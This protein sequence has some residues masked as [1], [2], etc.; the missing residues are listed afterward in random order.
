MPTLGRMKHPAPDVRELADRIYDEV[1]ARLRRRRIPSS[2]YRV[3]LSS[4]FPLH[5]AAKLVPYLDD[6]GIC[7]VYT[8]PYLRAAAGS[9]HGYDVVAH[10]SID[11]EMG[12]EEGLRLL[13]EALHARD[14]G[15]LVD[16][17]PNHMSISSE[18]QLWQDVLENGPSSTYAPFFDVVWKP[19]KDELEN[20]ILLPVLGDQYGAVL[21]AGDLRLKLSQGTFFICYFEHRFPINPRHY[22]MILRH[23]LDRLEEG[24]PPNDVVIEELL[25]ICTAC[26]NLPPRTETDP[27]KVEERRREKEVVKRRLDTL[28]KSS[29]AVLAFVEENVREFNGE[30]GDPHSFDLLDE[31]LD[32]QAYRL[33]HWRVAGE[34][35]NYRRFFDIN[36]LAAIRMEDPKVF[37]ETH[38]LVLRL[39]ADGIVQGLRID[40][41]DGLFDPKTYF[42]RIQEQH[43]LEVCRRHA[44]SEGAPADRVLPYV[45]ARFEAEGARGGFSRPVY[46]VA[47]KVLGLGETVPETWP[48]DGTTGYEFMNSLNGLF[49]QGESRRAIDDVFSRFTGLRLQLEELLYEKKK[50]IMSTSMASEVNLLA[51]QLNRISEMNRRSRDFTL[52]S[53][54]SALVEYVASFPVYRTYI[55]DEGVDERDRR[56]VERAIAR[57]KRR[58]PVVNVTIFDFLRNVLLARHGGHLSD[59]ERERRLD[60]SMK[61]QQLTGPVMAKALEDTCFYIYNRLISLNEVGGEPRQFGVTVADFHAQNGERLETARGSL[62]ATT[63]HDTKRS[64]DVRARIDVLSELPGEWKSALSRL[65]KAARK[66]RIKLAEDRIAPDRNEEYLLYQTLIGAWPF[67]ELDGERRAEFTE[68]IAAYLLKAAKE[69]KVETSWINPDAAWDEALGIFVRR[70]LADD[71]F[72]AELLPFQRRV[73]EVG[74]RNSLAQTLLKIASPGVPDVYQGCEQWCFTLVDP[75]NRRPVDFDRLVRELDEIR[76]AWDAAG[77]DTSGLATDLWTSRHDGRVKHLITWRCLE[78]RRRRPE[79]FL[80]GDYVPVECAGPRGDRAVAFCRRRGPR[81]VAPLVDEEAAG[82][83]PWEGTYLLLP[84]GAGGTSWRCAFTGAIHRPVPIRGSPTLPLSSLFAT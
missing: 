74:I 53:L 83:D 4:A 68:R 13:A 54:R 19:V 75:D 30:R 60:F 5:A 41:P 46:V 39:L 81:L 69:A 43:F 6:L 27:D 16:L 33:A 52:N 1:A 72:V 10:D 35:I 79:L 42:E 76:Q 20:K 9:T 65:S 3:Q 56:Y 29:P 28:C 47:E 66:H 45:R 40:H 15:H 64:E 63:T 71:A 31:L 77:D 50:L 49:V 62:L 24:L 58:S 18:N 73:A 12:G 25:S 59:E 32:E 14:M 26:D 44:E 17:V 22:P 78:A 7:D 70:I 21:E 57:A 38:R 11:Q 37:E 8:S 55:S 67:G 23:R 34:E 48:I 80:D 36:E 82:T 2:V 61:L 84:G 51:Y